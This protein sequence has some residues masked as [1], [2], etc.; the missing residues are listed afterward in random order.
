MKSKTTITVSVDVKSALEKERRGEPWDRF[1][2]KLLS[3]AKL[4]DK[5]LALSRLEELFT[6]HDAENLERILKEVRF[7]WERKQDLL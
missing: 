3:K 7:R 1:L 4:A 5:L 2:I 6:E